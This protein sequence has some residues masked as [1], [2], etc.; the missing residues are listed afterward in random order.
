MKTESQVQRIDSQ[1]QRHEK[2][3][4]NVLRDLTFDEMS[5]VAGGIIKHAPVADGVRVTM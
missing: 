5:K 4:S 2:E 1:T 3:Q